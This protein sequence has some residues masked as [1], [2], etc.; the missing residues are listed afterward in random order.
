MSRLFKSISSN[1]SR[2]LDPNRE[3]RIGRAAT[4][5]E[6]RLA[7]ERET[8]DLARATTGL[9]LFNDEIRPAIEAT[10]QSFLRRAWRDGE[11]S[12]KERNALSFIAGRLG[13][14]PDQYVGMEEA[15]AAAAFREGL[16]AALADGRLEKSEIDG[17]R[18]IAAHQKTDIGGLMRIY[19]AHERDGLLRGLFHSMVKDQAITADE[20]DRL[21]RML[22]ELGVTREEF[23]G[24]IKVQAESFIEQTLAEAKNDQ[25]LSVQE[26]ATLEWM[27][28]HLIGDADFAGYIGLELERFEQLTSL[29]Q[30]K[31]PSLV[32]QPLGIQAGELVHCEAEAAYLQTKQL[33]SGNRTLRHDGTIVITDGRMLFSSPTLGLDIKHHKVLQILPISGGVELHTS[34]KGNGA[35][36]FGGDVEIAAL[37]YETAVRRAN[38][39]IVCSDDTSE[40]RRI[41][42]EVRQRVFQRDGGRCVQ[43]GAVHYLEFDH[44]I[45]VAKGGSNS[46]NNVQLLCRGCNGRKSDKI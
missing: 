17:L 4:V 2:L 39:T 12:E 10:Y 27:A 14:T 24:A 37:I 25:L 20:W 31:L 36:Y 19:C 8:F 16:H 3:A 38:Q 34:G 11:I 35:W 43:C 42:R 28:K 1:V 41:P 30:G 44:I 7:A 18:R 26:K 9:D 21:Q 46:D 15:A 33:K 32:V 13:L 5:L 29:R 23:L 22:K 40:R 45:P 6:Q